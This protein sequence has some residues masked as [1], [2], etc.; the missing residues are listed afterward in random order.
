[1]RRGGCDGVRGRSFTRALE[2][3]SGQQTPDSDEMHLV[4]GVVEVRNTDRAPGR[5]GMHKLTVTDINPDV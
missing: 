4:V 5:R 3:H 2:D 1:M